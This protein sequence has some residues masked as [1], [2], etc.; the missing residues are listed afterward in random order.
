MQVGKVIELRG[1]DI[2]EGQMRTYTI[3]Q[4]HRSSDHERLIGA[5]HEDGRAVYFLF[6]AL[7]FPGEYDSGNSRKALPSQL[8][9]FEGHRDPTYY[10]EDQVRDVHRGNYVG[11]HRQVNKKYE[12]TVS[13]HGTEAAAAEA[14]GM[15]S[16]GGGTG[17]GKPKRRKSK[18]KSKRK[19]NRKSKRRSKKK[20]KSKR[21]S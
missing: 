20:K 3:F 16:S 6:F 11:D 14:A 19:S 10:F 7:A 1:G 8:K 18:R 12:V 9:M 5:K 17:G 21:R 15:A 2:P 13:Y 4:T